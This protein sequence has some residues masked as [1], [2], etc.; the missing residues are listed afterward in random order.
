VLR[1]SHASVDSLIGT[2]CRDPGV[3]AYSHRTVLLRGRDL[4]TPPDVGAVQGF[5]H[6]IVYRAVQIRIRTRTCCSHVPLSSARPLT[7]P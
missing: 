5:I 3:Q 2:R 6:T 7:S 1:Q 4:L